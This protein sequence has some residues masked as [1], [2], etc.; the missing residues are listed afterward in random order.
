MIGLRCDS[1]VLGRDVASQAPGVDAF[2]ILVRHGALQRYLHVYCET[3]RSAS[4]TP[5][6]MI[7]L[8]SNLPLAEAVRAERTC[9]RGRMTSRM[10]M[11]TR[12]LSS[13]RTHMRDMTVTRSSASAVPPRCSAFAVAVC[14]RA[15]RSGSGRARALFIAYISI[16]YIRGVI[17]ADVYNLYE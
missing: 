7:R 8:R 1:E 6:R 3:M 5:K 14:L 16:L 12:G 4:C 13:R 10:S 11:L 9:T 17:T 15:S 2:G